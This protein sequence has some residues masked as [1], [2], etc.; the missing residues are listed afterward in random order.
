MTLLMLIL[1][2]HF[3]ADFYFQPDSWAINKYRHRKY[4]WYHIGVYFLTLESCLIL[5]IPFSEAIKAGLFIVGIHFIIDAVKIHI[6]N[7]YRNSPRMDLVA[8]CMD[9][10]LHITS[11]CAGVCLFRLPSYFDSAF[12]IMGVPFPSEKIINYVLLIILL[13]NPASVFVKKLTAYISS[14]DHS[15]SSNT[16]PAGSLIGKLERL[17]IAVLIIHNEIGTIGFVLTAKSFAR[18]KQFADQNFTEKFLVGTLSSTAI[19]MVLTFL[20]T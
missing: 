20:L 12:E 10:I 5:C 4:L 18:Y 3:L 16:P 1:S 8:F 7:R 9:Q 13:F 6:C 19:A 17:I 2:A 15:V 14:E 11:I